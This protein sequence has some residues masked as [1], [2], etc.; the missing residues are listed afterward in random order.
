V[1]GQKVIIRRFIFI[2]PKL[3][4]LPF[5]DLNVFGKYRKLNPVKEILFPFFFTKKTGIFVNLFEKEAGCIF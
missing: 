1:P 4:Y 5:F 2:S 3:S